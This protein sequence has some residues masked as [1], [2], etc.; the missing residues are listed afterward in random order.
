MTNYIMEEASTVNTCQTCW[1]HE[2]ASVW[3]PG[4]VLLAVPWLAVEAFPQLLE[5]SKMWCLGPAAARKVP[6]LSPSTWCRQL[7]FG[8]KVVALCWTQAVP[9]ASNAPTSGHTWVPTRLVAPLEKHIWES[10]KHQISERG[11][12]KK[13]ENSPANTT[14]KEAGGV[15][16]I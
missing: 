16:V 4:A 2:G 10:A 15:W 8:I 3:W 11:E 9:G 5:M 6:S 14:A 1:R 12:Q 7:A 13:R